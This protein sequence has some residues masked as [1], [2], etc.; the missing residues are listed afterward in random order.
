[1]L[2]SA[3]DLAMQAI[4]FSEQNKHQI[5]KIKQK[6]TLGKQSFQGFVFCN[7]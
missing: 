1:M 5:D 6:K 4:E 3:Q 2:T 7:N